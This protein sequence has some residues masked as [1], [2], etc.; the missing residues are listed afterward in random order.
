MVLLVDRRNFAQHSELMED[1]YRFRHKAFVDELGWEALRKP[2]GREID[3][4]DSDRCFHLVGVEDGKVVSYTRFLPTTEPHLL[5]HVYP[6]ILQ[7]GPERDAGEPPY[8]TGSDIW[9]WTRLAVAREKRDSR[10]GIDRT[11]ARLF[12][13]AAEACAHLGI[14]AVLGQG[15]PF[16]LTRMLELGWATRPLALPFEYQGELILPVICEFTSTTLG[17]SRRVLE[18]SQPVLEIDQSEPARPPQPEVTP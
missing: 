6:E 1:V 13:A 7:V 17:T 9:E 8:P 11:S 15:H 14:R 2:D 5:S 10:K 12:V 3:Q 18:V 16:M 4:F